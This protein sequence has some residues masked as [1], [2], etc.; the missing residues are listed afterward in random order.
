MKLYFGL[1]IVEPRSIVSKGAKGSRK[2]NVT[3]SKGF[4][5]ARRSGEQS[6]PRSKGL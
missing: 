4:Q 2:Q 3:K 6:V 5:G 1:Q